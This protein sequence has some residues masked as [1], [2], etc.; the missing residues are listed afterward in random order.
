LRFVFKA[1]KKSLNLICW[2]SSRDN[3]GHFTC[4]SGGLFLDA[5]WNSYIPSVKCLDIT[6]YIRWQQLKKEICWKKK[7]ISVDY[8][9]G[10]FF[11]FSNSFLLYE[12]HIETSFFTINNFSNAFSLLYPWPSIAILNYEN[13]S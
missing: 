2:L 7:K 5:K 10:C 4:Q 11:T 3:F 9:I 13:P 8:I 1:K 6:L 12:D